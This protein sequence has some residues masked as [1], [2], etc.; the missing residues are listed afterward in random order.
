[1]NTKAVRMYGKKDLR[2]EEFSLP[3]IREDEILARV[4]SDGICMSTHKAAVQ[5]EDHKRVP[6]DIA[7]RPVIIGHEFCGEIVEV[8]FKWR[9][10]FSGGQK[11]S[12]QPALNQP[13]NP[14]EAL[15]YSFPFIG[16]NATY[17]VIPGVVM[18]LGCLLP[19][20][21][22]AYFCGSLAE[23]LSCIIGAFHAAYHTSKTS[24]EHQM[25]IVKGGRMAILAGAG[26]MGLGA[27]DY[28]LHGGTTPS[29]LV[30]TDIDGVKLERA[31]SVYTTED[32]RKRGISLHYVNT[33]K[34]SAPDEYLLSITGGKGFDDVF[35]FAPVRSLAEQGDAILGK[36]GCLN[37]FAGPT[38]PGLKAGFNL[39]NIHY[40]GT[41]IIGT[42]GG[43]TQDLK[44]ALN[45]MERGLLNPAS[46]ITHIG[47]LDS[48][49]HATLNLPGLPGGK[50]LIYTNIRMELTALADFAEKGRQNPMFGCLA[51]IVRKTGGLWSAEAER[52]LLAHAEK[53]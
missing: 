41:H 36:D 17:I 12:I 16:G 8:G 7:R 20:D 31:A 6:A 52:Y 32:A 47:G 25:G 49:A 50:K 45:L 2:L 22:E 19:Y 38:D 10:Q 23:P 28:A 11:F 30:V 14:Y 26:P 18:E 34:I 46:M 21:G 3:E 1:M 48:A 4:V 37:F 15:G 53:I 39:Y 43:N 44:E 24:Y 9:G 35:I 13:R 40:Q 29:L 33:A 51:E 27:I 42:S 5:G